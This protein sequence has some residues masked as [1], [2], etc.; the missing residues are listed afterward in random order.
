MQTCLDGVIILEPKGPTFSHKGLF[1]YIIKFIICKD[2][3]SGLNYSVN[4]I[5]IFS[6]FPGI[7]FNQTWQFSLPPQV[8]PPISF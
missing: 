4:L 6:Y 3:V 2:K 8:L 5:L 7:P 1:D